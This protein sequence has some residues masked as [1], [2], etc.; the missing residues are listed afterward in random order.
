MNEVI[1]LNLEGDDAIKRELVN[2][3]KERDYVPPK[4]EGEYS[5]ALLNEYKKR[6]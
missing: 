2:R 4:A 1:S 5:K 3:I 6:I